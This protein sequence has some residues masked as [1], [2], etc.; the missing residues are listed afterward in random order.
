MA[1]SERE[2]DARA[3][4]RR[5]SAEELEHLLE[6]SL[7]PWA[8]REREAELAG[9]TR[10]PAE[11]VAEIRRSGLLAAPVPKALGGAEAD[12]RTVALWLR[13]LARVAPST[14]I[15]LAM[16]LANAAN[17][18][19]PEHAVPGAE[20]AV[21]E[22]SK[23]WVAERARAGEILA[24]A[25]S[26][27]GAGGDLASTR[28][29]AQQ[30]DQGVVR[31]TGKKSFATLGPDADYFLCSARTDQGALD[32]FFVARTAPG[33]VLSEDWDALGMRSTASVGLS[34]ECTPA[35]R[36]FMYPGAIAAVSA[37]HW[38]TV[39]LGAVF[40]GVGEG[41][42]E[43][44][45]PAAR[46]SSWARASLAERALTL[47]AAAGF[48]EAVA[49]EDGI[50]CPSGHAER[51]GRAKTFAAQVALETATRALVVAG[52]RAY[53]PQHRVARML[54]HAAAGPLLRP[55]TPLAMDALMTRLFD[56][57]S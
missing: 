4:V 1:A 33:L 56:A 27:P 38:S 52:G 36:V 18:R 31:L 47:D 51:C 57:E 17:T 22:R 25:N 7:E 26:E 23:R 45:T 16:P 34:L 55:P 41:A 37:R 32:A 30:D 11:T 54:L 39:L 29:R 48:I 2:H 14:A 3:E 40:V 44:A 28:T 6:R 35:E 12:L 53:V 13:R 8:T 20:R 50:P 43:A 21:L 24:V 5:K 15:C 49:S 46:R 9:Q 42:L 19:I 10:L